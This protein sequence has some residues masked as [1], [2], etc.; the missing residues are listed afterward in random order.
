MPEA[1]R[2]R[3]EHVPVA[4]YYL[5][6]RLAEA[7]IASATLFG[8]DDKYAVR[9]LI[10]RRLARVTG[11]LL[12]ITPSG[13]A[14]G[15]VGDER[16]SKDAAVT[17][18][19][20]LDARKGEQAGASVGSKPLSETLLDAAAN[21]EQLSSAHILI[22]MRQA[23]KVLRQEGEARELIDPANDDLHRPNAPH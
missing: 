18:T 9:F 20:R 12:T 5:L 14:I 7:P 16:P 2:G 22:L 4:S 10:S 15:E 8:A 3:L 23:A 19:S 21:I 1:L 13:Q 17:R 11:S 6:R